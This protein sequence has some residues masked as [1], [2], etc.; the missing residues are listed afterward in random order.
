MRS[1]G[2]SRGTTRWRKVDDAQARV[3]E[4][5][6]ESM[7]KDSQAATQGGPDNATA[8]EQYVED[9]SKQITDISLSG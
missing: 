4:V 9:T 1:R 3:L 5:R 7:L 2:P 8:S 6:V